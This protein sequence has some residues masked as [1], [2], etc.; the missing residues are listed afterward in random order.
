MDWRRHLILPNGHAARSTKEPPTPPPLPHPAPPPS[1]CHPLLAYRP[2]PLSLSFARKARF[3]P[4]LSMEEA[5]T[6]VIDEG[7]VSASTSASDSDI[8]KSVASLSWVILG[9]VP[10]NA[11]DLPPQVDLALALK[12]PP[13]ITVLNIPKAMFL[14]PLTF[15][16]HPSVLAADPSGLLLLASYRCT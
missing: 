9:T 15:H 8:P 6:I 3:H 13:Q 7:R 16:N 5:K 4:L 14:S 12:V 1:L 11:S 2:A 10:R